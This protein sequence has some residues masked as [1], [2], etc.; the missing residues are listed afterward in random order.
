[1]Y[2]RVSVFGLGKLG[3]CLA[4]CAAHRGASVVGVD[5]SPRTVMLVNQGQSPV[6]ETGLPEMI[7][8]HRD[9]LV[10]T[11]DY[12]RAVTESDI[13]F[14]VVPTPSEHSG[15]FSL[16]YVNQAVEA[17]GK[18]LRNK[19][20]YHLVVV[21]STVLPGSIG[22]DILPLLEATSGRKCGR[23]LGLCYGPEFIALGDVIAGMLR[24][25]FVLI[26]ESD[27]IAG[28]YLEGWYR[29]FCEN[30]PPVCRMNF[31]NAELTKI[32]VNTFVT[33]K[34]TFANML[35]TLCERLPGG[36]VDVVTNA[37][38]HDSRI[39]TRYLM[40]GLGY[41]GPCFPRDN[42][43]LTFTAKK[44]G[45]TAELAEATDAMNR[46]F[47]DRVVA[48]I[49]SIIPKRKT[50][51][52]LGV[53]YKPGTNVVEESQPLIIAERLA[54][55]GYRVVIFDS[56][57]TE[58]AQF[59]LK[60]RV[61]YACSAAECLAAA[62]AVIIASPERQFREL[63]PHDFVQRIEPVVVFD[64]WRILRGRF[65]NCEWVHY[66]ALGIDESQSTHDRSVTSIA[67]SS[68]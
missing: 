56:H 26:G 15:R 17:I 63:G 38:G 33:T 37:L 50:I 54:V 2:Q 6:S 60:H 45:C 47:C 1:M 59:V 58:N 49:S 44:L 18:A 9:R 65:S 3:M 36:D 16:R 31:V 28:E 46:A 66:L 30:S 13:S 64:C 20:G 29:V 67:A 68:T 22:F 27:R 51:A 25:D 32:A 53:A 10:A 41:G 19:S 24:P 21:V 5:V 39:G 14:I 57:A 62:D 11:H 40:G 52:V 43:A 23:E 42:Q 4:A 55:A 7:G 34:I 61:S 8:A 35:A 48:R 12:M